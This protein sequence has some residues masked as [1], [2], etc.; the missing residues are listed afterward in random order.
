MS[1]A[2]SGTLPRHDP[3]R[4]LLRRYFSHTN[5]PTAKYGHD[6]RMNQNIGGVLEE[7]ECLGIP[8]VL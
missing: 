6:R 1:S 4:A 5:G 8:R 7:V 2:A 3:I